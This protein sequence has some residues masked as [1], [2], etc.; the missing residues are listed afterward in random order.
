[1]QIMNYIDNENW[2]IWHILGNMASTSDNYTQMT[3]QAGAVENAY[4]I[5]RKDLKDINLK[6]LKEIIFYI[7]NVCGG[8]ISQINRII[9][10]GVLNRVIELNFYLKEMDLFKKEYTDYAK[11]RIFLSLIFTY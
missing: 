10:T 1:M 9:D 11:V 7:S 8:T 2:R 3:I 6:C 5:L 4:P